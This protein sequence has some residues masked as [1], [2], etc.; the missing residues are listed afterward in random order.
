M[1]HMNQ[2]ADDSLAGFAPATRSW[3]SQVFADPT[4]AQVAAWQAIGSR[5]HALVV[6]PTGSGKTLAAFLHC[7]DRLATQARPGKVRVL[8]VSPLKALAVDIERN[9]RAPL[10]GIQLA[11]EQLGEAAPQVR[12]AVR[13]GDTPAKDRRRLQTDPPDIL[14]TTPESLFLMLS[15]QVAETLDEVETIIVDEVHALAGTKRGVHLALSMERLDAMSARGGAQRIGL[16]A[17]VTPPERVAAFLGG[18]RPVTVVAPPSAKQWKL[19]VEV[20]LEDMTDLSSPPGRDVHPGED[21][22]ANASIWPFLEHRIL[23]LVDAHRSTICFVNSRRV[24]ERLTSHLNDLHTERLEAGNPEPSAA[25]AQV[26]A[27]S[28]ATRGNDG[29]RAPVVARAHHGSVSKERRAEIEAQLKSGT[30]PCVVATSSLE[31]GIDMGAVDLVIQVSSPPSVA[32]G[33]QRIGRAG[34]QVGATSH[35]VVLPTHR[36]DLL[37]AAVVARRMMDNQIESVPRL[38][39]PLDV[40]AQHLVSMCVD[41]TWPVADALALVRRCDAYRELPEAVWE[42]VLDMLSGRYP[43]EDFAE[44]KPRLVWDRVAQTLTGRP[45]A[46][47]LVVTSGGTIP[48]RGLFG[49]FLVG[50]G[51]ASG[52]REPGRRVGE[53]DEEMVYESRVGDVFTLG[54]TSWRIEEI[55]PNQ[56]LVTSAAGLAG[57]LPFWTSDQPSRPVEVGRAIGEAMAEI[58][59]SG[60]HTL[61]LPAG[62]DLQDSARANLAGLVAEQVAATSVVPSSEV[63]MVERFRDELGDWRVCI[64]SSLGRRVLQP[65]SLVVEARAREVFGEEVHAVAGNDG[66]VLHVP[67][68]GDQSPGAELLMADP[69]EVRDLVTQELYGSALFASRFRECAARALLLPRR[70]PGRRTPLWQQRMRSAQ[71]LQVAGQYRDFPIVLEAMRECLEDVFD[72]PQLEELLRQVTARRVRVVEVETQEAS[73]MARSMMFG[74]TG[75]FIYDGDQPLAERR[76]AAL[77]LDPAL[78]AQLLG[79]ESGQMVL[80][81]QVVAE[82]EAELQHLVEDRRAGS[83]EQ[84]W[85]MLRHIGPLG[86]DECRERSDQD[87]T[88]WLTELEAAGRVGRARVAGVERV[89]V[90]DDFALLRDGLGIPVPAGLAVPSSV[91]DPTS[92]ID[93][94]VQ[95]WC[96]THVVVRAEDIATRLGI[97]TA[98]VAA[99]LDAAVARQE[100]LTGDFDGGAGAQYMASQVMRTVRRR[101]LAALRHAVEAVEPEGF[102]HFLAQWHEVTAPPTGMDGLVQA[103][104]L[105]AGYP[106]PS[107]MLETLVLPSRVAGYQPAMLEELLSTGEVVWTGHGALGAKDGWVQLWPGDAVLPALREDG[108]ELCDL[109][110]RI[111][112]HLRGGGAWRVEDLDFGESASA[113]TEALWDLVWAGLVTCDS[114]LPL[115][116]ASARGVL[117]HKVAARPTRRSALRQL[118]PV[119]SPSLPGRWSAVRAS[120]DG[121][122]ADLGRMALQ[123]GR[124][125]VLTR[126]SVLS[127]EMGMNFSQAYRLMAQLEETGAVRRG[128][129]VE[130]LGA[131]QFALP[132]VV[133]RLREVG[134]SE[135]TETRAATAP[136]VLAACDPANPYGASL[137]WPDSE[138][139]RPTRRAGALVVLHA[140]RPVLFLERGVRTLVTFGAPEQDLSCALEALVATA[141]SRSLPTMTIEKVNGTPALTDARMGALLQAAGMAMTPQGY[142]LRL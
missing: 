61:R 28:G 138:G 46:R 44:F 50:T 94:L 115:R 105:L 86:F 135:A 92:A 130:G 78:L 139:H 43:S 63:L 79:Q 81:P 13:S 120:Q 60:D 1:A 62:L 5:Q 85:D 91:A 31:L 47:R 38:R 70:T 76:L 16:S 101:T 39:N 84:F 51:S 34:H 110:Q 18:D 73:P 9:L 116:A 100:V 30:L 97:G 90:T 129:F 64:H 54:T 83:A 106:I 6:A 23:E 119:S 19:D 107:S 55:T 11:A 15:S 134:A 71:L 72:L 141:R 82:L 68:V 126:G 53:L 3:F 32:S 59:A 128:Y 131:A 121:V 133:D 142:R 40:L 124:Y 80:D 132:G 111:L 99:R 25:P 109:S 52:K 12:V 24:A 37:E 65:L 114:F 96:R 56:V 136:V 22:P 123:L 10:R 58:T 122:E 88:T 41:Q 42:S 33:L 103:V 48:D 87:P 127:E 112:A 125:G 20:P 75:E 67:D 104:E 27:Q 98:Q 2:R 17:T 29:T 118:R 69:D 45:G 4:P 89:A 26:M 117:K 137:P 93:R 140:G 95:R 21:A 36:N 66:I 108:A 49:V 57:R 35:G 74:Y 14:I 102:A 77:S 113:V 7:L 8:Y